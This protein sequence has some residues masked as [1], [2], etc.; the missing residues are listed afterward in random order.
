M[1]GREGGMLG[2]DLSTDTLKELLDLA[3]QTALHSE[4]RTAVGLTRAEVKLAKQEER[5]ALRAEEEEQPRPKHPDIFPDYF[6]P[7]RGG[8][9]VMDQTEAELDNAGDDVSSHPEASQDLLDTG[10]PI[11]RWEPQESGLRESFTAAVKED[12]SLQLWK[13]NADRGERGF[14]WDVKKVKVTEWSKVVYLLVVPEPFHRKML[15]VAH[16]R[17]GHQSLKKVI[18]L[19]GRNFV[20]PNQYVDAHKWYCKCS[21]CQHKRK[22]KPVRAPMQ[23]ML[24]LSV[25][26]E[27]VA[28]DL[29][30]PFPRSRKGYKYMLTL[31]FLAF[32]YPEAEP[33]RWWSG[34]WTSF[35]IMAAHGRSCRTRGCSSLGVS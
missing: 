2:L 18:A 23:Q 28:I 27:V 15:Q 13:S 7:D 3:R 32:R 12:Q 6:D 1:V 14:F 24:V 34:C 30:G 11:V 19:L 16:D 22:N 35:H 33:R 29:V 8:E 9:M 21:T 31:I 5:D 4:T 10:N 25:P 17:M 20:W 26:F